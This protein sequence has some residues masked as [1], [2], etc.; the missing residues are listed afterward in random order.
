[1][2]FTRDAGYVQV[3]GGAYLG[4]TFDF[5]GCGCGLGGLVVACER[6]RVVLATLYT[7]TK[8]GVVLT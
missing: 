5:R 4:T 2:W 1:M 8:G 7:L 6:P 3:G